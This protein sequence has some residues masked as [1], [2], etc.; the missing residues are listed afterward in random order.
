[1]QH[2]AIFL[3]AFDFQIKYKKSED[4]ANADATSRLSLRPDKSYEYEEA[5]YAEISL[6]ET[7]PIT[8][9]E[10][11][12]ETERDESLAALLRGL[13]EGY[14]VSKERFNV[15]QIEFTLQSG[16]HT[17]PKISNTGDTT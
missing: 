14:T 11:A 6:I 2:Y 12:R 15:N 17:R 9:K 13:K 4:N 10:L 3:Q 16:Y 8:W 1:M 7:L 5:D